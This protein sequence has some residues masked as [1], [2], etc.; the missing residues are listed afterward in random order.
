MSSKPTIDTSRGTRQPALGD[1]ADGA[2]RHQV[3][4]AD[5]RGRRLVEVEQAGHRVAADST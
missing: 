3:R 5:D 4:R 1:G 2:E